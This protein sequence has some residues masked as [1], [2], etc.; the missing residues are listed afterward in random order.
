VV[1]GRLSK[2]IAASRGLN[3]RTAK[4]HRM[5]IMMKVGVPSPAQLATLASDPVSSNPATFADAQT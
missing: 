1:K 3:E 4:L 2:R 5:S